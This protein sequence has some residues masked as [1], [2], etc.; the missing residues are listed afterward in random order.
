MHFL[1]PEQVLFHT[2]L[3]AALA[4]RKQ[5]EVSIKN[6]FVKKKTFSDHSYP[7]SSSPASGMSFQAMHLEKQ[8]GVMDVNGKFNL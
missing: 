2:V 5:V 7:F 8:Q 6:S 1:L 3:Y 4:K